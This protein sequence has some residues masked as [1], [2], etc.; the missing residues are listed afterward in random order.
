MCPYPR[1]RTKRVG[2]R[3]AV[4][5]SEEEWGL[6]HS[7]CTRERERERERE[8]GERLTDIEE[9]SSECFTNRD[10]S[11][12]RDGR[13]ALSCTLAAAVT[14]LTCSRLAKV[15]DTAEVWSGGGGISV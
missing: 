13:N 2:Q 8:R 15:I 6:P 1:I 7:S 12:R 5:E 14:L 10:P 9:S 3:E 4:K 11:R